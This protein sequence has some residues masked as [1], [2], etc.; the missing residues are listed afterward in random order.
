MPPLLLQTLLTS[1]GQSV[2]VLRWLGS[3]RVLDSQPGCALTSSGVGE[4]SYSY[5]VDSSMPYCG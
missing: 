1:G 3:L 4:A 5:Q 2:K